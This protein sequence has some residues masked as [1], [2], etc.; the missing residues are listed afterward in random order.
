[1]LGAPPLTKFSTATPGDRRPS[2]AQFSIKE[3]SEEALDGVHLP[4]YSR[5]GSKASTN[6]TASDLIKET[7]ER[8]DAN[9]RLYDS[10]M[11]ADGVGHDAV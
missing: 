3:Y 11:E 4:D 9:L 5:K 7:G 10:G 8:S 2:Q 6:S 1:M